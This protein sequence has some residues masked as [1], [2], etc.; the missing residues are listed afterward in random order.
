MN[1]P[2]VFI[3]S[4]VYDFRDLR[5]AL[6]FWLEELGYEVMLSEFN[7]FTKPLDE[8]SYTACIKAI[9]RASYFILLIGARTGGLFGASQKTSI[10]RM[11]YRRGYELVESGKMKLITTV[12]EIAE[13]I[14]NR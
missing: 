1:K 12:E 7:D 10:T 5:S 4:T 13:W 11:E 8:N 2:A 6:K 9:E 3:S 14:K